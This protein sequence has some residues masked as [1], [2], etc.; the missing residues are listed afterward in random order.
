MSRLTDLIAQ[1]AKSDPALAKDLRREIDVLSSRRQFG[2]N[3]ERHV[4]ESVHLPSRRI[5]RGD[6]VAFR[7]GK[8]AGDTWRVVGFEGKG[9]ER[10]ARL[11]SLNPPIWRGV[12][13][14]CVGAVRGR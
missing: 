13:G 10:K 5:R 12:G 8:S 11:L 14:F 3:F 6:K 1:V 7:G 9:S 2:L 4:P